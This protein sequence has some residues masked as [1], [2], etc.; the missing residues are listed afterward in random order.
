MFI[1]KET[2]YNKVSGYKRHYLLEVLSMRK[3][4]KKG[5]AVVLSMAVAVSSGTVVPPL[6]SMPER[7]LAASTG[8]VQPDYELDFESA[9]AVSLKGTAKIETGAVSINGTKYSKD[10][11]HILTLAG[12]SK[13]S[14]Y[15]ELPSDL[16]KGV[17]SD[18]GFS[19]SFW[20]KSAS[21]VGSYS[22]LISS[23]KKGGADE[24]AYAPYAA[25]KVWNVI[26]DNDN[27]YREV[28]E[29]E[30][31][32]AVWNYISISVS[33]E[34]VGL[35]V[36]GEK[37]NSS[38]SAGGASELEARLDSMDQMV[39]NAIGKTCSTWADSDCKAQVDDFRFYKK[40][41]S[42]QE[43][44]YI[45][46]S[47]YGFQA[48]VKE[49]RAVGSEDTY[50]DGTKLTKVEEASVASP[51]GKT[52]VNLWTDASSGSC[53]YSASQN[54]E[55]VLNASKLGIN[56]KS[57]DYTKNVTV[58]NIS[59]GEIQTEEYELSAGHQKDVKQPYRELS[60]DLVS[61]SN[62]A[63]KCTVVFRL[64]DEG[65]AYRYNVY[66]TAGV[67][68]TVNGEASEFVLPYEDTKLWLGNTSNTYEVDYSAVTMKRLTSVGSKYTIPALAQTA[69]GKEWVLLTEA[70]VF[71][72]E[73]P[74]CSSYLRS[75]AGERNLKVQFGN[76]VTSVQMTYNEGVF[77]TPWRVAVITD[78]LN[79]LTNSNIV[80]SLNPEADE[81]T[82]HYKD[83]VKSFKADWSWWSEA[84]DD[85]I[86]Y[87]PQKDYID[88]AAENGW[89]AVCLDFGWCLW[90]NYKEKVA[91]LC[92]YAKTKNVKVMLWYGVNN[93]GH[94]GWKDANGKAAY[95]TYSLR[96][97]AQLEEQFTW[98]EKAGVYAVKVDYY[99][100][101]SQY[102]MK[103]MEECA[104]IAAKHKLCVLF[105]G[106]TL[107]GGENRTYPNILSYE[108]VFGEEYH[109]FGLG[110]PTIDTLLT[111]PYTRNVVGS[112][113]FTP[114][115][116]PVVSIPATAAFQLAESIVF[117]SGTVNLA[118]S[119]Y[120]YEGNAALGF[121]NQVESSF[122]KSLLLDEEQAAPGKYVAM[123]RKSKTSDKWM[124]GVMT[125]KA[126]QTKL[127]L[128][129]LGEGTYQAV[130]FED[131]DKG[132]AVG[133]KTMQV[134]KDTVISE[135][136]KDN[137]GLAMI[138]SKDA[139]TMPQEKYDYYE[140]EG[141]GVTLSG[142]ASVGANSFA[143]GLKQVNVAYGKEN[144]A[145][146]TVTVKKDGVYPMNIYYKAGTKS[147][148]AYEVNGA[149]AVKSTQ[150]CSGTNSIAKYTCYVKL[151][152]GENTIR[153]YNPNGN[154]IGI[155]RIAVAKEAEAGAKETASDETDYGMAVDEDALSYTYT[156]YLAIQ[157]TTNAVKEPQGYVGW[158]GGSEASYL[159]FTVNVKEA[160]NYKLRLCYMT[161]AA[162]D[163]QVDVNGETGKKYTCQSTGG[164]DIDSKGY[165]FFDAALK[166]GTNTI[167]L[168]NAAGECPNIYS[169]GVSTE[170]VVDKT[171]TGGDKK[172]EENKGTTAADQTTIKTPAAP[173]KTTAKAKITLKK[174]VVKT[175]KK[176]K[177]KTVTI[178]WKKVKGAKGYQLQYAVGKKFKKAKTIK[179]GKTK[180]VWKKGKKG[181]TYY[182]RVRAYAL[183]GKKK[184]YSKWSKTVKAVR[185]K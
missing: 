113:D 126:T 35:Y 53:F 110:S 98:A 12:G 109:K 144:G 165:L 59:I 175:V 158:L 60:F 142:D 76:K 81:D 136:L 152:Q 135:T 97:T 10:G 41:L 57:V 148:V 61:K 104:K 167:T 51:D 123:A 49:E 105:H 138:V 116:L 161:G 36:N 74:Y 137:G 177:A 71:N 183:N 163:V 38:S 83:W 180:Y 154:S 42:A 141:N 13:G 3:V 112:M 34:E 118:S 134:T 92:D 132:T 65:M 178:Q 169:L 127:S 159:R 50:T 179:T 124:L 90:D 133:Y 15:V 78:N 77:H 23:A 129:F 162:R 72:E 68:E 103:Q 176:K 16:Y 56:S 171:T 33:K 111:Y 155:D 25:D 58:E 32:K 46:N 21:N 91:Q 143:S 101:D 31:E 106:C 85:P 174:P 62:T 147:Q 6:Q 24:F 82:Y 28:Y 89:D 29:K 84:G 139:I 185:K 156:E 75:D 70:N 151:K 18:T 96:T 43:I 168:K 117:E 79:T 64:F 9:S 184:V 120:A 108:A 93:T 7:A 19:Y 37:V 73:E 45:A 1:E 14:S 39:L 182:V 166:A 47:D 69:G 54:G 130:L 100:S 95:P 4:W 122:E 149:K 145:K 146:L 87:A 86:E 157:G 150:I 164:Y 170:R 11:N 99:E 44:A 160:G 140:M 88:F 173:Q 131:N 30:P 80:T 128:D 172:T 181:K 40:A 94:A 153:F 102:T 5:A 119:I 20:L 67:K 2:F 22:R 114:A 121:L 115:A 27:L 63:K 125:K 66:G 8:T 52:Q 17:S 55:N 26:F 107:P 48:V